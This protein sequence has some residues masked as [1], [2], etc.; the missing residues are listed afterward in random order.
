MECF[1]VCKLYLIQ[2]DFSFFL[3]I[4]EVFQV[5][6][7]DRVSNVAPQGGEAGIAHVL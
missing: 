3:N 7:Q 5:V 6:N 4:K 1:S 2:G